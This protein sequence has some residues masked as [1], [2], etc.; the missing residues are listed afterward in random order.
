MIKW[1]IRMI[2]LFLLGIGGIG[3]IAKYYFQVK[4]LQPGFIFFTLTEFS[5]EAIGIA[6]T[7]LVLDAL[8]GVQAER[9]TKKS[10]K[11][12]AIR[13]L[14]ST[15]PDIV[16]NG[17]RILRNEGWLKD[18]SLRY[19]NLREANLMGMDLTDADLCYANLSYANLE[20][21]ILIGVKLD[22]ADLGMAKLEGAITRNSTID[23]AIGYGR[24]DKSA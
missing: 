24:T 19:A 15:T 17:L 18:G 4:Q 14:T 9:E 23:K 11:E 22:F 21:A 13:M 20:N 8:D 3:L 6:I 7:V 2:G 12:N 16:Q 5:T 10:R 1:L